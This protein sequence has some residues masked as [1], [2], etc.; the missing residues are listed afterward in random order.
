M[1][2]KIKKITCLA[3]TDCFLWWAKIRVWSILSYLQ[4]AANKISQF[5]NISALIYPIYYFYLKYPFTKLP[6][7]PTT[8]SSIYTRFTRWLIPV[9]IS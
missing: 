4:G 3:F 8:Y 1:I 9:M 6:D 7:Y 2:N 5:Q